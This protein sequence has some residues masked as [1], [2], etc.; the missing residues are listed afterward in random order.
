M[1]VD[2]SDNALSVSDKSLLKFYIALAS[3]KLVLFRHGSD[4]GQMDS[5]R[6]DAVCVC[7]QLFHVNPGNDDECSH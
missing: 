3:A 5:F 1:Y 6:T 4:I 2:N 7:R